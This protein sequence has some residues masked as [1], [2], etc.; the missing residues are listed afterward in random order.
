MKE[1]ENAE[2][3]AFLLYNVGKVISIYNFQE[4]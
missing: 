3:Q 2:I 4:R 1:K